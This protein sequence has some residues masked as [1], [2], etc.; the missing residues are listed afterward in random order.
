MTRIV[1][2]KP[3]ISDVED[4]ICGYDDESNSEDDD[5]AISALTQRQRLALTL[6]N[7]CMEEENVGIVL[8]EGAMV[9]LIAMS[10]SGAHEVEVRRYTAQAFFHL[11]EKF[12]FRRQ[13]IDE[14]A[15]EALLRLANSLSP[16]KVRIC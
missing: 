6:K 12:A 9:P 14:G 11:S 13:L 15:T 8:K 4:K 1:A 7:W 10:K 16:A 3:N 2:P 5:E